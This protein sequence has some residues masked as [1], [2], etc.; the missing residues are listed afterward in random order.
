ML[1]NNG[2]TQMA[3]QGGNAQLSGS[4]TKFYDGSLPSGWDPMHKQGAIILGS[5]GDCCQ[6]NHNASA[7]TFYEGAMVKGYP[8]D[9]ALQTNIAAAGYAVSAGTPFTPGARVSLQA[10]TTCCTSDHLRHDDASTKVIISTVNSS[11]SATV[12]ADASWIVRAEPAN[13]S[14]VSFESAN[15]PGQYLRHSNFE[16]YLNTD[17]GGVSFAQ[18]ATFCPITGNSGT[19]HSFQSVN[20]PTKYIRRYTYT[21]YIAGNSRSHSWDNA[22]SWAAD[23]SWLVDQPWS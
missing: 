17:N 15:A 6:T 7:G 23:T 5:G 11:S 8:S 16:L 4:L 22:T 18:D 20:Y 14:C 2:T 1:K 3:L 9:A 13:G 21:A 19:G 12:K 10:T